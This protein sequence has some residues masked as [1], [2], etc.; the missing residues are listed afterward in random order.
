VID[1]A[2]GDYPVPFLAMFITDTDIAGTDKN[3]FRELIPR[4]ES[5]L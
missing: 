2:Y 1:L 5:S 3:V 4:V